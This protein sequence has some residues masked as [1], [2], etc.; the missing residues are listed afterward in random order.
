MSDKPLGE[1]NYE[2]FAHRYEVHRIDVLCHLQATWP[3]L[4]LERFQTQQT[5]VFSP[6][7]KW[8]KRGQ[9]QALHLRCTLP[10]NIHRA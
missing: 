4:L 10:A 2:Q 3:G 9:Q 5:G 1:R 6:A 8:F 7:V